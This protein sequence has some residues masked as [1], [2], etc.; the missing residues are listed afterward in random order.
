M[1][2][3]L[4]RLLPLILTFLLFSCSKDDLMDEPTSAFESADLQVSIGRSTTPCAKSL[5]AM[6][7]GSS[8]SIGCVSDL[9]GQT[10][11]IPKGAAIKFDGGT[12][13]NGTLHFDG[14][15]IDGRLLNQ[16]LKITGN[17]KLAN[18]T[19]TFEPDQWGIAQGVV[20]NTK[21]FTNRE[22][23][24]NAIEE[25]K[26]LGGTTFKI[27]KLDA[28]FDVVK[29]RN[30]YKGCFLTLGSKLSIYPSNFH[31]TA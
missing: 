23:I 4:F 9:G 3:N 27:G 10:I 29:V 15:T 14:G 11:N 8:L 25:V 19:Y 22:N 31:C 21:A 2:R 30:T 1:K 6:V 16:N 28:Y 26:R 17:V 24:E 13:L 18:S 12:I 7:G 20:G 5:S